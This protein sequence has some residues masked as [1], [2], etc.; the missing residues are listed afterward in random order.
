MVCPGRPVSPG[1]LRLTR[2][3]PAIV[4]PSINRCLPVTPC[5]E[6]SSSFISLVYAFLPFACRFFGTSSVQGSVCRF[7]H[8]TPL[9]CCL[10]F[11]AMDTP[12]A[13][14]RSSDILFVENAGRFQCMERFPIPDLSLVVL[15]SSTRRWIAEQREASTRSPGADLLCDALSILLRSSSALNTVEGLFLRVEGLRL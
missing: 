4:V 13:S 14:I 1:L 3:G 2:S 10:L 15:T 7:L 11:V 12:C 8:R 5:C 9:D 6:A